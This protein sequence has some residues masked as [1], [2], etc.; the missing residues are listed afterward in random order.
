MIKN[1]LTIALRQMR[2]QKMY[3]AIKIGGLA[4]G[5]ATCLLIALYIRNELS[6]DARIPNVDRMY[7][8]IAIYN[9]KG[10]IEKGT[11][12]APP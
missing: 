9:N 5:I 2:K 3:T 1:Y 12:F 7:R 11:S 8:V 10:A 6:Y 4:L